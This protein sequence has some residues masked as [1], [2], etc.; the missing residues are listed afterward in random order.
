MRSRTDL[1]PACCSERDAHVPLVATT[2]AASTIWF[3]ARAVSSSL[4]PAPVCDHF[5]RR[6]SG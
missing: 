5:D 3:M 6:I 1:N 2:I 4:G